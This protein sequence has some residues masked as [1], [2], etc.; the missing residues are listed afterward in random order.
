MKYL[1]LPV[2]SLLSVTAQMIAGNNFFIFNYLD[3]ALVLIAYWAVYHSRTQALF[4]GSLTGL[5]LDAAM[6]WPLGYNGFSKTLA[7]LILGQSWKRFNTRES[8][9]QFIIIAVSSTASSLSIFVLFWIMQKNANPI[10]LRSSLIRAV[11]TAFITILLFALLK[12]YKPKL[13][14]KAK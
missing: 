8:W 11:I 3:L 6:G 1:F 14:K 9:V 10:Y 5:L 12:T 13:T 7:A 4:V 2:L